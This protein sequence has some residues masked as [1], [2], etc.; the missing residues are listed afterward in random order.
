MLQNRRVY[1]AR[2][3]YIKPSLDEWLKRFHFKTEIKVRVCETDLL[4]HVNSTSYFMY[5][6]QAR[7]EYLNSLGF[8]LENLGAVTADIACHYHSEAYFPSTL[9]VGVRAAKLGQKSIDLEY[10]IADN[11]RF[12]ASGCG[13]IVITD[14]NEKQSIIIPDHI[15]K[16]I[17]NRE[18][19]NLD[20]ARVAAGSDPMSST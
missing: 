1:M 15:R 17:E 7:S 10:Y 14:M 12:V 5:F 6:E 2:A 18:K 20:P 8:H 3:N 4:G 11:Q 9:A 19:L 13:T 16:K